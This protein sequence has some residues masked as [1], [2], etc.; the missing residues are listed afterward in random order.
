MLGTSCKSNHTIFV[1]LYLR[2]LLSITFPWSIYVVICVIV[3]FLFMAEKYS[4]VCTHHILFFHSS[5]I[6]EH[7]N[8]FY[9]LA[10]MNNAIMK[11]FFFPESVKIFN[12]ENRLN[13]SCCVF[14]EI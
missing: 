2:Y 7:L 8:Y 1:L 13:R 6:D 5:V 4:T 14:I 3:S 12:P 9:L 11:G 10:T